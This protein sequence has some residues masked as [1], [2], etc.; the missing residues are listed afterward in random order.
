MERLYFINALNKISTMANKLL[1]LLCN[2]KLSYYISADDRRSVFTDKDA[3]LAKECIF[4][5]KRTKSAPRQVTVKWSVFSLHLVSKSKDAV[6]YEADKDHLQLA[7]QNFTSWAPHSVS[8]LF[9]IV[10]W[11]LG[12]A[13]GLISSRHLQCGGYIRRREVAGCVPRGRR[14]G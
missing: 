9:S 13:Q 1:L 6:K 10:R 7:I 12:Q 2:Q 14:C 11:P 4:W 8:L 5:N 3:Q